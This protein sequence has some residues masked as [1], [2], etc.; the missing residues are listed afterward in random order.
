MYGCAIQDALS[1]IQPE[2]RIATLFVLEAHSQLPSQYMTAVSYAMPLPLTVE[3][4]YNAATPG[5][6]CAILQ[7]LLEK[8]CWF[9]FLGEGRIF[10]TKA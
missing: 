8:S 5:L 1:A 4:S 2:S 9:G 6:F 10:I 3:S 7:F